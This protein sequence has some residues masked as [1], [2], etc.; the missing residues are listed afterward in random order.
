MGM[1]VQNSSGSNPVVTLFGQLNDGNFAGKRMHEDEVPYVRYWD[2]AI[3]QSMVYIVPSD[4]QLN[5]I[6]QALHDG[7][8][9]FSTL[10]EYGGAGGGNSELPI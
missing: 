7:N 8:L 5:V 1:T 2:N 3:D 6:L 9:A 10:Q 4:E